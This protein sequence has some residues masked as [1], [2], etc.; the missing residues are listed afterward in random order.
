[1]S[2]EILDDDIEEEVTIATEHAVDLDNVITEN[3]LHDTQANVTGADAI[4]LRAEL[5]DAQREIQRLGQG[6][7]THRPG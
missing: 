3:Q 7:H 2:T 1:M 5:N 4:Q 6:L